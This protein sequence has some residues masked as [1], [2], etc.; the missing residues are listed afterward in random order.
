MLIDDIRDKNISVLYVLFSFF[1][2]PGRG[3]SQTSTPIRSVSSK[4][5]SLLAR[6]RKRNVILRDITR[7]IEKEQ[8]TG[9][10]AHWHQTGTDSRSGL[11]MDQQLVYQHWEK[12]FSTSVEDR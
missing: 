3:Y 5:C 4:V 12:S 2:K 7:L 11:P 8:C 9:I 10:L 1:S 6:Y